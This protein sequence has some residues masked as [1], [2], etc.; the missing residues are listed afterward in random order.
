MLNNTKERS[1]FLIVL[2]FLS[3]SFIKA[4]YCSVLRKVPSIP[5]AIL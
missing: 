3:P 1:F 5:K 4:P 2:C